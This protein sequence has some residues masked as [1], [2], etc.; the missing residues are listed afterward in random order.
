M[1]IRKGFD[2]NVVMGFCR[3]LW[4]QGFVGVWTGFVNQKTNLRPGHP[5]TLDRKSFAITKKIIS[6]ANMC[7][8]FFWKSLEFG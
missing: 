5:G 2:G 7:L 6:H 8:E 4:A 3:V 1:G